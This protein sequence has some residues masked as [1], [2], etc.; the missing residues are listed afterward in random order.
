MP[1]FTYLQPRLLIVLALLTSFGF[2]FGQENPLS[3]RHC[4]S[5]L[6]KMDFYVFSSD[7]KM[8]YNDT[9]EYYWFKGQKLHSTQGRSAGLV[10]H[11]QF[12]KFYKDGQLAEQGEFRYGLKNGEWLSWYP[13]GKLAGIYNYKRGVLHGHFFQFDE[14][15]NPL[16]VGRYKKGIVKSKQEKKSDSKAIEEQEEQE[17]FFKRIHKRFFYKTEEEQLEKALKKDKRRQKREE[18]KEEN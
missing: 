5:E 1:L 14:E 11:G 13:S 2:S 17:G 9:L 6:Y 10:L 7:K 16:K 8:R 15:G 12:S 4:T 18:K 3:R